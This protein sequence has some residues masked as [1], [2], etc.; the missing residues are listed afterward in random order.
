VTVSVVDPEGNWRILFRPETPV[1][2]YVHDIRLLL[3]SQK[4]G[5]R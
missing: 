5:A 4:G 1:E 2:D 3:R